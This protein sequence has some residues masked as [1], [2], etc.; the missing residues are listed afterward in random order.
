MTIAIAEYSKVIGFYNGSDALNV[1]TYNL[2][3][4]IDNT[5]KWQTHL[6][7]SGHLLPL[8]WQKKPRLRGVLINSLAEFLLIQ[9]LNRVNSLGFLIE[10]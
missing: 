3:I 5:P 8:L 4:N 7:D 10:D 9:A 1:P 6:S 2:L